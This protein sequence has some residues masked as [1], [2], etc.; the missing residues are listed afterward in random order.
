VDLVHLARQQ[1]VVAFA[2]TCPHFLALD[3]SLYAGPEPERYLMTPPLRSAGSRDEL[4]QRIEDGLIHSV[5]SDHCGYALSQRQGLDDFTKASPGIPGVETSLLLLYTLGV[6]AH[7]M[8]L[9]D[10]VRLLSGG[11]ARIFG[12]WPHKGA[13]AP[14]FDAD[15]VLFDPSRERVLSADELHSAAGY[16]P[17]E[18]LRVA[19][20]VVTTLCRGRV[21]WDRGR[22]PAGP[23]WGRF[24]PC[25]PFQAETV[26]S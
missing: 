8:E 9:G 7:R 16:S 3:D 11:P 18:G 21:V 6:R 14:G 25:R 4:W 5:G 13:L 10:M 19:G 20:Q 15:V 12:L 2:E 17:Y 24:V 23:G 26:H 22:A 1:G